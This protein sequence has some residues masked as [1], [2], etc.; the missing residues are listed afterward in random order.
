MS[1]SILER[2]TAFRKLAEDSNAQYG[3]RV[4]PHERYRGTYCIDFPEIAKQKKLVGVWRN[5]EADAA[6]FEALP[7]ALS[8]INEQARIIFELADKLAQSATTQSDIE[9]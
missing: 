4:R 1:I 7:E 3:Y 6:Y 5:K 8:I 2:V 9:K